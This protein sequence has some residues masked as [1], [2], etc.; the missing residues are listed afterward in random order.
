MTF[1]PPAEQGDVYNVV[2]SSE[3]AAIGLIDGRFH[4]VPAV[5]HKEILWALH[6]GVRV[7]GAASMGALRAVELHPYGMR[8][9]GWIFESFLDGTFEDDDEVAVSHG[10]QEVNF[11]PGSDAMVNI[12]RTL[13]LAHEAGVVSE[14]VRDA[15]VAIAKRMDYPLR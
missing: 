2:T 6:L 12:R 11:A 13:G 9:T 3:P 4:D 1:L 14:L 7:Y 10:D 5:W 15:L 8:G